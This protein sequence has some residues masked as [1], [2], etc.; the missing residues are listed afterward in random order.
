M[1]DSA[2]QALSILRDAGQ[3]QWYVIPLMALV[4]YVYATEFQNKNW[5][6]LFAGLTYFGLDIFIEIVNSLIFHFTQFAPAWGTPGKTAYLML[7]GMNVEICF[8]F[9]IVGIVMSKFLPADK[10]AKILGIPGRLAVGAG[11]AAFCALVEVMLNLAGILTWE[12]PWWN[13]GPASLIIFSGYFMFF[14]ISFRV[15]DMETLK[16]K[17]ITVG[18]LLGLDVICLLVF[19]LAL[20][21]I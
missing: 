15:H 1:A 8:M 20:K 2:Q 9:A 21:W 13:T 16:Q 11:A 7:I 17:F 14:M 19:C 10:K 18:S 6:V 12:Y 4:S 3:L 5:N